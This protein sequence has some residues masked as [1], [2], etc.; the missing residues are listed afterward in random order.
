MTCKIKL[1][2]KIKDKN[3]TIASLPS[4]TQKLK[5]MKENKTETIQQ[6]KA[7]NVNPSIKITNL[8]PAKMFIF[9]LNRNSYVKKKNELKKGQ[10]FPN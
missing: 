4:I 5:K 8:N 9:F 10:S 1:K 3:E 7:Q 2:I 6:S